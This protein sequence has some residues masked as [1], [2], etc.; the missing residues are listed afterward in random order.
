MR[1][2]F[3]TSA[4]RVRCGCGAGTV[5]V[6]CGCSAGAVRYVN[7]LLPPTACMYI[8]ILHVQMAS[9]SEGMAKLSVAQGYLLF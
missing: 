7:F 1:F 6:Q 3:G 5:Q 2:R 9:N 8:C 4:V